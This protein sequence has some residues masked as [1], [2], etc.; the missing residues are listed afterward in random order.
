MTMWKINLYHCVV[1]LSS[2]GLYQSCCPEG[3][4][5]GRYSCYYPSS[6]SASWQAASAR[7][8]SMQSNLVIINDY[9]ENHFVTGMLKEYIQA[10]KHNFWLDGT[11]AQHEGYFLWSST[12]QPISYKNW[13]VH[14]PSGGNENCIEMLVKEYA[15]LDT[16]GKWNDK[17]CS[18]LNH[19]VCERSVDD[20]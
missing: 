12:R 1:F 17:I 19:F 9:D 11:D 16:I 8:R 3:W 15:N 13:N 14:E 18:Y 5:K 2:L 4:V 6:E 7:C 10:Y 20:P